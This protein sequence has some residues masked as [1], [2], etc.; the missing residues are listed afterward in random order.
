MLIASSRAAADCLSFGTLLLTAGARLQGFACGSGFSL[1]IAL[2]RAVQSRKR[3]FAHADPIS[4]SSLGCACQLDA[5]RWLRCNGSSLRPPH[6][7]TNIGHL[8]RRPLARLAAGGSYGRPC[9][10]M[11]S[12]WYF[13]WPPGQPSTTGSSCTE[14]ARHLGPSGW[15]WTGFAVAWRLATANWPGVLRCLSRVRRC[16]LN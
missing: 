5:S 11:R 12:G 7:R 2:C 15:Y 10:P 8:I 6:P 9:A 1:V 4:T 3:M 13:S 14:P 16:F